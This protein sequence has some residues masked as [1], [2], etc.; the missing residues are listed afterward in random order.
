MNPIRSSES[1]LESAV[2]SSGQEVK[3]AT[4]HQ[5]LKVGDCVR[6]RDSSAAAVKYQGREAASSGHFNKIDQESTHGW[7]LNI[8]KVISKKQNVQVLWQDGIT[9][10]HD[11]TEIQRYGAFEP[12]FA[13]SALVVNRA[14]L[15]QM[16]NEGDEKPEWQAFNEMTFFESPHS[17]RPKQI[18]VI[19]SVDSRERIAMVRWFENPNSCAIGEW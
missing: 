3:P 5:D 11:S 7:D 8:F 12:D 1:S 14:G 13:P 2:T 4:L 16:P 6:F 15:R 10:S 18:G 9:V 19:Q 17:L